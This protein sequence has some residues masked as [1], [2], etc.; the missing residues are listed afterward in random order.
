MTDAA[1][2]PTPGLD[3]ARL[4]TWM[5]AAHPHLAGDGTLTASLLTGG[6]SNLTYRVDGGRV[7]MVLRRPPLGHVQATA[8]DMAR[9]HRVIGALGPTAVPVPRALAL[10]DDSD[11]AAGTGTPFYL[12][13]HEP[14]RALATP[15]QNAAFTPGGLRSV[16]LQLA[17]LLA[18]LHA[19]D[20]AGVGLADLGR[21]DGFLV[22]Q[23]TR[24]AKQYDGSRSRA[25]PE[26]DE[27]QE[28]LRVDVPTSAR[29]ALV[30]GDFRLDNALVVQDPDGPRISAILDWEMSTLGDPLVDV[31]M[32]GMYWSIREVAPGAGASAVDPDAGYPPFEELLDTYAEHRGVQIPDLHWYR[33]FAAYKLAVILEGV[34]FRFQAGGTVGTGFD[35]IGALVVP[36]A[37][38]G[39]AHVARTGVR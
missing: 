3:V 16:S 5:L 18:E 33:A 9:E 6:R 39:L 35:T 8:H 28:R 7:P 11:G 24:W 10:H 1:S 17:R 23:L 30:H 12:M 37:R 20:P 21:P 32:L 36:L 22:R 25:L 15:E 29:P 14:G 34:H 2:D 26:L 13:S 38:D 27:L 4:Q 31:G 19:V